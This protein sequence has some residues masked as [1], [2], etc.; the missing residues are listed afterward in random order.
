M[1]FS[2]FVNQYTIAIAGLLGLVLTIIKIVQ[3]IRTIKNPVFTPVK[4]TRVPL[5]RHSLLTHT[6]P[7]YLQILYHMFR[8]ES[9]TK[10]N[11]FR[12]ILI[13]QLESYLK[14]L[15]VQADYIDGKC[16]TNCN[17]GTCVVTLEN[18]V[19]HNK[20]ILDNIIA[21][22]SGFYSVESGYT[23]HEKQLLHYGIS[24]L[25]QANASHISIIKYAIAAMTANAKYTSCSK[26]LQS[27][28]FSA[29][30]TAIHCM[31]YNL[32]TSLGQANGYFKDKSYP[33]KYLSSKGGRF[34]WK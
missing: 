12:D 17:G 29:Y 3:G 16:K 25:D 9:E 31:L 18:L 32:E 2:H 15:K 28:V 21:E 26:V 4:S 6:I 5:A 13:H 27:S 7:R 23:D 11:L 30:E 20:N 14:F 22:Y 1:E 10:T 33:D 8:L 34:Q 24:L 19:E